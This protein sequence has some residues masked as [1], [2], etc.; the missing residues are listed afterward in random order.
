MI[1][2]AK[3]DYNNINVE[4]KDA[5]NSII[6]TQPFIIIAKNHIMDSFPKIHS[7]MI[8]HFKVL[9][10]IEGVQELKKIKQKT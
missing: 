3:K 2:K 6:H 9:P 5:E 8:N 7:L 10:K 4:I 1:L